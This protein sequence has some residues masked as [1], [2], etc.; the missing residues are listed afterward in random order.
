MRQGRG[1]PIAQLVVADSLVGR[2]AW[3]LR[4]LANK[5]AVEPFIAALRDPIPHVQEFAAQ[6]LGSLGDK[7]AVDPLS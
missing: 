1:G 3:A 2:A 5:R 7:R 4:K 6:M